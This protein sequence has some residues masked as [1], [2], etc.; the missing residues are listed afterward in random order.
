MSWPEALYHTAF[1][2]AMVCIALGR[3]PW[4]RK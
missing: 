2:L 1:L 4:Q 3:W